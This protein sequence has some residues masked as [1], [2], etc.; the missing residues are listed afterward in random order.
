[1]SVPGAGSGAETAYGNRWQSLWWAGLRD[2]LNGERARAH[3]RWGRVRPPPGRGRVIWVKTGASRESVLLGAELLGAIRQRRLDVRLV[4]TF[5]AEHAEVTEPRLKGMSKVGIGYGPCDA[6]RA[7]RRVL[8]RLD[9]FALILAASPPRPNLMVLAGERVPHRVAFDTVPP[10]AGEVEIVYPV[11]EDQA[12]AWR[13]CGRARE[14]AAPADPLT[15]LAEAQVEPVLRSL[16]GT[17]EERALW[18]AHGLDPA[19]A[20]ALVTRWRGGGL[21]GDGVLFISPGG[22]PGTGPLDAAVRAAGAEPVAISRW[23]RGRLAPGTIVLVDDRR[24][25]P[26]ITAGAQGGYLAEADRSALWQG[27]AAG[28]AL[29]AAPEV[30][31]RVPRAAGEVLEAAADADTALARWAAYREEVGLARRR[32]DAARR[33]FWEARRR[34]AEMVDGFLQRVFDW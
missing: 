4:L 17:G 18:W 22:E 8:S 25:L 6:P 1:M 9:P 7:V 10:S 30:I 3:A 33:T 20:G 12:E 21:A 13:A 11:D 31:A 24:W 27:L 14:V 29:L 19:S 16:A 26:A 28:V 2:R 34:S 32:G 15:L 23:D 5:E